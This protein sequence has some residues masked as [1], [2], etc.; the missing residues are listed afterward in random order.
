M[1]HTLDH[2]HPTRR[3]GAGAGHVG[4]GPGFVEEHQLFDR[5]VLQLL[6]PELSCRLH[7]GSILLGGAEGLFFN[8]SPS[9]FSHLLIAC[10]L[11][12]SASAAFS[13]ARV[14]SGWVWM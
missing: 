8:T 13:S 7:V 12:A 4:F 6:V 11:T 10:R 1:R 2:P 14:A 5:H 3:S 9:F